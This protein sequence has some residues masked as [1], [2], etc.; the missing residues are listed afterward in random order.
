MKR[1]SVLLL[2]AYFAYAMVDSLAYATTYMGYDYFGGTYQDAEKSPINSED[3]QMCWAATASNVLNWTGWGDVWTTIATAE[4][5]V[6]QYFQDHWTDQGG[7]MYFGIDWWF[8]GLNDSQGWTGW[9]QVDLDGGG[10][11][12]P[13]Y[14]VDNYVWSS[15]D[16]NALNNIGTYLHE[17]R[18]VGLGLSGNIAHAITCWGYEYDEDGNYL[19]VYITDSD[20]NKQM[21]D[22]PDKLMYYGVELYSGKWYLH[23]YYSYGDYNVFISEVHGLSRYGGN[24]VPEPTTMLLLG[25]GLVGLVGFGRKRFKK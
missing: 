6:F 13:P 24:P 22:P 23:D 21:T 16:A 3:D 25:A 19:G 8:D 18:G 14:F 9:S 20:D 11:Y 1:I 10:F 5:D 17:G 15:D 12:N 2:A 4:D 7:N